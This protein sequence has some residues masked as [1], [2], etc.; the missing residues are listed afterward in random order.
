MKIVV[1]QDACIG[2][3]S[4][5]AIAAKTFALN[6]EG[7]VYILNEAPGAEK[8]TADDVVSSNAMDS[9]DVRDMII[10]AARSCPTLAIKLFEDDGTEII[11]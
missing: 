11:L 3:A 8:G 7:K 1:D 2:A 10:E 9:M 4:C 6:Q 5:V